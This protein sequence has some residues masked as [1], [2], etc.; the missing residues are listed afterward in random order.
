MLIFRSKCLQFERACPPIPPG[1]Q[2]W[3]HG[4][5]FSFQPIRH[6]RR[7]RRMVMR[8]VPFVVSF[9]CG[10][11]LAI[12]TGVSQTN[13]NNSNDGAPFGG[14]K[15]SVGSVNVEPAGPGPAAPSGSS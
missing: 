4:T 14:A 9:L 12:H 3:V 10:M 5:T 1:N 8:N 11:V 7:S 13:P 2:L 6:S 15:V